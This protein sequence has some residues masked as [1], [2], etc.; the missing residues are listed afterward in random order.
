[1]LL[2]TSLLLPTAILIVPLVNLP[3]T[4]LLAAHTILHR[5]P[6]VSCVLILYNIFRREFSDFQ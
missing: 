2:E 5:L 4:L 3:P 6:S 1:M